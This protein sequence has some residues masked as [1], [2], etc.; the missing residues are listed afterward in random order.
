METIP[1]ARQSRR[2]LI[3]RHGA[4]LAA[5]TLA[6]SAAL[7]VGPLTAPAL[8]APVEKLDPSTLVRGVDAKV[9]HLQD[10]VLRA[11][12]RALKVG[13]EADAGR[14]VLLG[15]SGGDRLVA[16]VR[17]GY[18]RVH[19]IRRGQAPRLVPKTKESVNVTRSVGVRLSRGG[20]YLIWT[21]FDRGGTL[22]WGR[23]VAD[24]SPVGMEDPIAADAPL[25]AAGSRVL[26]NDWFSVDD[27]YHPGTVVW[28][29]AEAPGE[30]GEHTLVNARRASGGFLTRDVVFVRH[31]SAGNYGPTAI[32]AP[33]TP[34]W[35]ARFTPLDLSPDGRRVLGTS[36]VEGRQVLQLRRLRDGKVYRS[37]SVGSVERGAGAAQQQSA[38]FE[39]DTRV[40]FEVRRAG[41]SALVRCRTTGRC[42]RASKI[43]GPVSFGYER[44]LWTS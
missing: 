24:G 29:A 23:R 21:S 16:S 3:R 42:T 35:S 19:R 1:V 40:V 30:S 18:L 25:D 6:A 36:K 28:K 8:A 27:E 34:A 44:F 4:V 39:S 11:R 32:S 41:R 31:G 26:H 14:Q 43:R 7:A 15:T 12:G 22:T 9:S 10:G 38:R 37:W 13:V 17:D 20:K 2:F 5:G 33:G